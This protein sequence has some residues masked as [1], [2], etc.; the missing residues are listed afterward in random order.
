MTYGLKPNQI[1]SIQGIFA[2]ASAVN[3]AILFGSRAKGNYKPGSDIDIAL[4]GKDLNFDY[5]LMLFHQLE[6]LNLPNTFDLVIYD[7]IK[8]PELVNH[9]N[10]VGVPI[11]S[12]K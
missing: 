12:R 2:A 6:D 9:I 5:L 4:M 1:S 7:K 10:R 3:Q 8:E 11:F